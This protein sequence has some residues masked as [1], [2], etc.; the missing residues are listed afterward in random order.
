MNK[1]TIL[2]LI[3]IVFSSLNAQNIDAQLDLETPF[4]HPKDI[5]TVNESY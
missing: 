2:V 3:L 4:L 1:Y 5:I